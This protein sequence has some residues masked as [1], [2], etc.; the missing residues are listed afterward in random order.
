[1]DEINGLIARLVEERIQE[2]DKEKIA[3]MK[4]SNLKHYKSYRARNLE[5]CRGIQRDYYQKQKIIKKEGGEALAK[6]DIETSL[7]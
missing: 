6:N 2:R 1:M 5:K 4:A 3:K 7:V